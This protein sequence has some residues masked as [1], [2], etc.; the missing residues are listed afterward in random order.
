MTKFKTILNEAN[1]SQDDILTIT[2]IK[3]FDNAEIFKWDVKLSKSGE[4][5]FS[6]D[7]YEGDGSLIESADFK[8]KYFSGTITVDK[9]FRNITL[10]L[11]NT[12]T[13]K[14]S[15]STSDFLDELEFIKSIAEWE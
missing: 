1:L 3:D 5:Y 11:K 12:N 9:Y 4:T 15:N 7:D 13:L 2:P 14:L 8:G 10:T 6:D